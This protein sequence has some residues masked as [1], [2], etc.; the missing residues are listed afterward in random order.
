MPLYH[1]TDWCGSCVPLG[2]CKAVVC[3]QRMDAAAALQ[4]RDSI[5]FGYQLIP[6]QAHIHRVSRYQKHVLTKVAFGSQ[7][8]PS[9]L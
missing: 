9:R 3:S 8:K 1:L 6:T 2:S 4:W 5:P 7:R